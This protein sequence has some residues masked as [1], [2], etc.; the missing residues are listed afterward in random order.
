MTCTRYTNR[1]LHEKYAIKQRHEHAEYTINNKTHD[2]IAT[3]CNPPNRVRDSP[4]PS[5]M[6]RRRNRHDEHTTHDSSPNATQARRIHQ[7]SPFLRLYP[8]RAPRNHKSALLSSNDVD[9]V[10]NYRNLLTQRELFYI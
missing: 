4:Q 3:V 7:K 9:A 2:T 10:T 8:T 5:P 1:R 6:L